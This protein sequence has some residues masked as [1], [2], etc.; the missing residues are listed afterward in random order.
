M[1]TDWA[2][3]PRVLLKRRSLLGSPV[4]ARLAPASTTYWNFFQRILVTPSFASASPGPSEAAADHDLILQPWMTVIRALAYP[5]PGT[6]PCTR[7]RA[8]S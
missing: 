4:P 1:D 3:R 8:S 7:A 2:R 6:R 5:Q